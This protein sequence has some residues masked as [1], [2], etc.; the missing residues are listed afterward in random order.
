MPAAWKGTVMA[1]FVVNVTLIAALLV[2]GVVWAI[3]ASRRRR[4]ARR[5]HAAQRR[6]ILS[7]FTAAADRTPAVLDDRDEDEVIED[8]VDTVQRSRG[9]RVTSRGA[10]RPVLPQQLDATSIAALLELLEHRS[11][12]RRGAVR[13]LFTSPSSVWSAGARA[14]QSIGHYTTGVRDRSEQSDGAELY[15]EAAGELLDIY[16]H[17]VDE[18]R[19]QYASYAAA[20]GDHALAELYVRSAAYATYGEHGEVAQ[21]VE[22]ITRATIGPASGATS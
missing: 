2:V 6:L 18:A 15:R 7:A 5:A 10:S 11:P 20:V 8:L 22:E 14:G 4:R 21:V 9:G 1:E 16:V 19:S 3:S 17:D 12:G 13:G